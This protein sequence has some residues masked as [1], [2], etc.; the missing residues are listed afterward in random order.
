MRK[1]KEWDDNEN[2]EEE[3]ESEQQI[4]F[5]MFSPKKANLSPGV[6]CS[7]VLNAIWATLELVCKYG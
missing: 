4:V 5:D 1:M 2:G 7:K 3:P 6:T